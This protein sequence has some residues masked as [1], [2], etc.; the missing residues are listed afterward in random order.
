MTADKPGLTLED[1]QNPS[2][3]VIGLTQL[4]PQLE[5]KHVAATLQRGRRG[6]GQ[7]AK[8]RMLQQGERR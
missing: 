5:T 2:G 4:T 8:R 7:A 6:I 3:D 1:D